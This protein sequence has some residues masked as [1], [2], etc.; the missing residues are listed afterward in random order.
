[1]ARFF[2]FGGGG[3]FN[4][5]F[6]L[7]FNAESALYIIHCHK[8][9]T[10]NL[11]TPASAKMRLQVIGRAAFLL[12]SYHQEESHL[13]GLFLP[14]PSTPLFRGDGRDINPPG[15][16]QRPITCSNRPPRTPAIHQGCRLEEAGCCCLRPIDAHPLVVKAFSI[17]QD[18][19][20]NSCRLEAAFRTLRKGLSFEFF[21]YSIIAHART[22]ECCTSMRVP[23]YSNCATS[24][25]LS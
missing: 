12:H 23:P 13:I 1:M 16:E 4:E 15:E 9:H 5:S 21:E 18:P 2:F 24:H 19:A 10:M 7:L 11:W 17:Q 14:S 25:L 20:Q 6:S 8:G 22:A 3:C